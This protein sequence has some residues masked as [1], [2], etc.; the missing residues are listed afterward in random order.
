MSG[1]T[2]RI[3]LRMRL[4]D[5]AGAR[6]QSIGVDMEPGR[7]VA[8]RLIRR[9]DRVVAGRRAQ[10]A[11]QRKKIHRPTTRLV[12]HLKSPQ[13][14]GALLRSLRRRFGLRPPRIARRAGTVNI[15]EAAHLAH[16][17][18]ERLILDQESLEHKRRLQPRTIQLTDEHADSQILSRHDFLQCI[19]PQTQH[20]RK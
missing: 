5:T 1:R 10:R 17:V 12:R 11:Q 8:R 6:R 9:S 13:R 20:R 3:A 19:L 16:L 15:N 14:S 4:T 18:Q 7:D 2:G